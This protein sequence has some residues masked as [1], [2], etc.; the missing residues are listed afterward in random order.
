METLYCGIAVII[1]VFLTFS[2]NVFRIGFNML[3]VTFEG[4][5]KTDNYYQSTGQT[6]DNNQNTNSTIDT[7][8]KNR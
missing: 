6:E 3:D 5:D 1:S 8:L 4:K 2:I 7:D